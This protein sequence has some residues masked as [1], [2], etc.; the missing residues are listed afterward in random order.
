[1]ETV[2]LADVFPY[3]A[4]FSF[5]W[6]CNALAEHKPDE[7][8]V[9]LDPWNGSGTTTLAASLIGLPSIG[10]DLNPVANAFARLR[11]LRAEIK[12]LRKRS[13]KTH[14]CQDDEPL[15]AWFEPETAAS[16]RSWYAAAQRVS[17][18]SKLLTVIA[19]FK[20]VK[21]LTVA[22]QGSNPTW[23][24]RKSD[25]KPALY[26]SPGEIDGLM[27]AT[28]EQISRRLSSEQL[29]RTQAVVIDAT[30]LSL[31]IADDSV[32]LVLTSPPYFTRIDYGVAYSRELAVLGID[33]DADR[34]LRGRLM[35][36]TLIRATD[37]RLMSF[38][39]PAAKSLVKEI[40][41]HESK[42]SRG[43]Y[44]KQACQYL[45]DL[46]RSFDEITRVCASG[47]IAIMVVQDS[48]YKDIPVLLANICEEEASLRGWQTLRK[49]PFQVRRTL[50]SLNRSAQAYTKGDVAE[51]V[52]TMRLL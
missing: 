29:L 1:M 14:S 20:I 6:A 12:P 49:Q 11:V 47:A 42:A 28:Q 22:F 40:S 41:L 35:G 27:M 51:T 5:E 9:V 43:Y 44:L 24:M 2:G 4:G 15:L 16:L 39:S 31:P 26:V 18:P 48:Y 33:I 30:V 25:R 32:N 8:S 19:L 37:A 21:D 46:T 23:V 36:T 45:G 50:T 3:Y 13:R 17:T 52:L 7:N 38:D 10:V 34:S